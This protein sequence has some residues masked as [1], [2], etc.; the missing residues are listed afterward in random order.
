MKNASA[1]GG[2]QGNGTKDHPYIS[3]EQAALWFASERK[4]LC[5][6]GSRISRYFNFKKLSFNSN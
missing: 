6:T 4:D 2:K 5:A 3:G 1:K